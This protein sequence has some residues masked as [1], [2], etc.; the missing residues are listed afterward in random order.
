[1]LVLEL[2]FIHGLLL[3]R[4]PGLVLGS[5]QAWFKIYFSFEFI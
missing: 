5:I 2:E 4:D 3:V 1:V